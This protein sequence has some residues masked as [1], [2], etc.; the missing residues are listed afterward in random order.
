MSPTSSTL[1][2]DGAAERVVPA[3]DWRTFLDE[4]AV[5]MAGLPVAIEVR[6]RERMTRMAA[7]GV[8][9]ALLYDVRDDVIEIAVQT[10]TSGR[11]AVMRHLIA[12]P[13][14]VVADAAG[15][16]PAT[17]VVQGADGDVTRLRIL[18]SPAF[19]G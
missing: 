6:R 4:V 3:A 8:L 9:H 16:A 12:R 5:E 13:A 1:S 15:L 7:R 10:P 17:V 18:P 19:S 11:V 14:R 2:Q